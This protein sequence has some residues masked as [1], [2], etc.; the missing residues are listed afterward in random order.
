MLEG[1]IVSSRKHFRGWAV[2][3]LY[4]LTVYE[5]RLMIVALVSVA[6]CWFSDVYL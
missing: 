5:V 2:S 1:L 6:K 4:A 3:Y